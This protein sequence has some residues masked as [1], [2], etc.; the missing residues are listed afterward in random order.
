MANVKERIFEIIANQI[1][2]PVEEIGIEAVLNEDL[3]FDQLDMIELQMALEEEFQLAIPDEI[4]EQKFIE[5]NDVVQYVEEKL[6][7]K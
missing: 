6:A 3:G 1:G 2:R 7:K 5:V 4:L